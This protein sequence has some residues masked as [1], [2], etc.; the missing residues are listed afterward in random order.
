VFQDIPLLLHGCKFVLARPRN[1][2]GKTRFQERTGLRIKLQL[3]KVRVNTTPKELTMCWRSEIAILNARQVPHHLLA[4]FS[5]LPH[6][7]HQYCVKGCPIVSAQLA[8]FDANK[9]S[10]LPALK[11]V[12]KRYAP[13]RISPDM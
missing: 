11:F 10:I 13:D 8:P 4:R 2:S 9:H 1:F 5:I 12:L 6:T 7:L 3:G